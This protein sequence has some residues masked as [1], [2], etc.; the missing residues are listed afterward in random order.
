MHKNLHALA[1]AQ[2]LLAPEGLFKDAITHA[3]VLNG[4]SAVPVV[5]LATVVL[6]SSL[7]LT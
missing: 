6:C 3:Q 1:P 5:L 4:L 7:L 2:F